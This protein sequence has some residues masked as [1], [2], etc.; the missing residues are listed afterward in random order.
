MY[1]RSII[2]GD[3]KLDASIR[4]ELEEL[5]DKGLDGWFVSFFISP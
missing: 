1:D 4:S 2:L 5:I 3:G